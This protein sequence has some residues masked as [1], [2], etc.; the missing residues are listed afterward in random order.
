MFCVNRKKEESFSY[1]FF[2]NSEIILNTTNLNA[3]QK[4]L[5]RR[6]FMKK[7][8][9]LRRLKHM[10]AFLFYLHKFL[11]TT[12]GVI[13]PALLSIQYYF[14]TEG[15]DGLD[16]PIY[17][18]AWVMSLLGGFVS[19]YSNIFKVDEKFFLLKTIYQK[20]KYEGW[21][22]I[23]LCKKYDLFSETNI[24]MRHSQLFTMFVDVIEQLI[25]EYKKNDMDTMLEDT[26]KK[27]DETLELQQRALFEGNDDNEK[28]ES[29]KNNE[30]SEKNLVNIESE[31]I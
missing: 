13:V 17:W 9:S 4:I 10:Y 21:C 25:D 3:S 22:F 15:S 6:R 19:A 27:E 11:S 24:K 20:L 30:I 23:L 29:E 16:N 5:F 28:K 8:Y 12:L 18:T 7:L 1:S 31:I 2:T 14:E 26:K